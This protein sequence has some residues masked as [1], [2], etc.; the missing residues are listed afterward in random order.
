MEPP[1]NRN[2]A[3]LSVVKAARKTLTISQD[4]SILFWQ[5]IE[6]IDN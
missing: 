3:S 1:P 6:W 4:A 2:T 5:N